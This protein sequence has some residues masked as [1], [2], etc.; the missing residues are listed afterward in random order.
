MQQPT[1]FG[2]PNEIVDHGKRSR[3][4]AYADSVAEHPDQRSRVLLAISKARVDG[5]TREELSQLLGLPIPSICGRVNE[6]KKLDLVVDTERRRETSSGRKAAVIVA[7]AYETVTASK[8][9]VEPMRTMPATDLPDA[10]TC[11]KTPKDQN[12]DFIE[13]GKVYLLTRKG[14]ASVRVKVSEDPATSDLYYGE[15]NADRVRRV[16]QCDPTA[17]WEL[18]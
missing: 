3:N 15:K 2:T 12:G 5:V 18:V 10:I 7:K 6:L 1:L 11:T 8:N 17:T 4:E 16:D 9:E 13:P 14:T